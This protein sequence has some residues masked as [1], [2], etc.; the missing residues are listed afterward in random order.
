MLLNLCAVWTTVASGM[1]RTTPFADDAANAAP[2]ESPSPT[3]HASSLD[4]AYR[5][6]GLLW[7][8]HRSLTGD[9]VFLFREI[10]NLP[11]YRIE[12]PASSLTSP[13]RGFGRV[14]L[15]ST[16][17]HPMAAIARAKTIT[18]S[19]PIIATS[20]EMPPPSECRGFQLRS[21][22]TLEGYYLAN[23]TALAQTLGAAV[24]A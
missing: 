7:S 18:R 20:I 15:G 9:G 3:T 23:L 8:V 2:A 5:I 10:A 6:H 22:G 12:R 14:I 1:G 21:P 13:F 19:V 4:L 16:A 17:R 11:D 24:R